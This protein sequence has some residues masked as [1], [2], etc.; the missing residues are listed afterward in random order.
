MHHFSRSTDCPHWIFACFVLITSI[1][2]VQNI[3]IHAQSQT[4]TEVA[5]RQCGEYV[6]A[7]KLGGSG[8]TPYL[9]FTTDFA[10]SRDR[11]EGTKIYSRTLADIL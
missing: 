9:N 2:G 4:P 10:Q 7:Y 1:L 6:E 8:Y 11:Q 3:F 5:S